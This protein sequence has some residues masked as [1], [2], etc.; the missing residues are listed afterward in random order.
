MNVNPNRKKEIVN[1]SP[2][3]DM[4]FP[5]VQLKPQQVMLRIMPVKKS[6]LLFSASLAICFFSCVSRLTTLSGL[7]DRVR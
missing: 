2:Y 3:I 4:I 6:R 5:E 7:N 1:G